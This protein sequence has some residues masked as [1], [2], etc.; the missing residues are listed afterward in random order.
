MPVKYSR[1]SNNQDYND[2]LKELGIINN[3]TSNG[4]KDIR[5]EFKTKMM[6]QNKYQFM[7]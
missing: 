2:L 4:K 6:L 7:S 3:T 1:N 5:W